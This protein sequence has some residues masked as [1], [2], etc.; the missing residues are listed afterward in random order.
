M[1]KKLPDG[2]ADVRGNPLEKQGVDVPS[3]VH[4]HRRGASI[5]VP[6]LLVRTALPH[7]REPEGLKDRDDLARAE[8][9]YVTHGS[10][11]LHRRG[12][13]ELSL[14]LRLAVLEEHLD[15][16]LEVVHQFLDG[17]ALRV[18]AR[19]ARNM[20]HVQ[21]R[22]RGAFDNGCIGCICNPSR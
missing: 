16:F 5:G 17:I 1:S 22:V 6:E 10:G 18:S 14:H 9:G 13:D 12:T 4:R 21:A 8:D 20:T 19:K 15:H 7:L 11:D 3:T 2:Q